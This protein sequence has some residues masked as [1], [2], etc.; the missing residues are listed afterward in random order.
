MQLHHI[1][2][3]VMNPNDGY[4]PPVPLEE[5]MSLIHGIAST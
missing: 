2:V 1:V 3:E 5:V 4:V